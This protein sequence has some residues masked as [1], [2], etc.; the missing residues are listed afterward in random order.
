MIKGIVE[1]LVNY[2][3][4]DIFMIKLSEGGLVGVYF[5]YLRSGNVVRL[6]VISGLFLVLDEW[7][8]MEELMYVLY[9]FL[10]VL[11]NN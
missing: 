10:E 4:G 5:L 1:I 7:V 9:Y 6:I 2:F 8:G 3:W 11:R